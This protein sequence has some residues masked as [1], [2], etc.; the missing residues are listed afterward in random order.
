[1][2]ASQRLEAGR[3]TYAEA[4]ERAPSMTAGSGTGG[5]QATADTIDSIAANPLGAAGY[6]LGRALGTSERGA[7]ILAAVGAV[8]GDL[9][10]LRAGTARRSSVESEVAA[11]QRIGANAR[12]DGTGSLARMARINELSTIAANRQTVTDLG[13]PNR[14]S[15]RQD[16]HIPPVTDGRS[17]LTADPAELLQGLINGRYPVLRTP[18]PGQAV[19]D[20][21][22]PIG[23]FWSRQTGVPKLVGPTNYGSVLFG[24]NGT[25]IVPANPTQW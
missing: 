9:L 6:L 20:F 16:L 17:V 12:A 18:K 7:A 21:G 25:H 4:W 1:V 11:L 2:V 10:A 5:L 19:V 22:Q 23:E 24:K 14:L 13:I 3:R 15:L 8:S